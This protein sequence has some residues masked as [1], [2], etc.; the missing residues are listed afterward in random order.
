MRTAE[1]CPYNGHINIYGH[2]NVRM[3]EAFL[4]SPISLGILLSSLEQIEDS[5][6]DTCLA[7]K[8]PQCLRFKA[9]C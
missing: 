5:H 2:I 4:I 9:P 1:L 7:L 6:C 3:A 8:K